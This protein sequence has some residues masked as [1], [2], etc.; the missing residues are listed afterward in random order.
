MVFVVQTEDRTVQ[1][2]TSKE[3][4]I[5]SYLLLIEN[6]STM[7]ITSGITWLFIDSFSMVLSKV[8]SC[9]RP[10]SKGARYGFFTC[11]AA[12]TESSFC[13]TTLPRRTNDTMVG[14]A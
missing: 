5:D 9:Y 4:K 8:M 3:N 11:F 12:R 7:D 13:F 1:A 6:V 14:Q 2:N 10:F